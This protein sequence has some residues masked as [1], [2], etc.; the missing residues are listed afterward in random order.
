MPRFSVIIPSYLQPFKYAAT[1]RAEKFI[2][3]LD[4]LVNQT[5]TDYE[6][7]VISDGCARTIQLFEDHYAQYDFF[8]LVKL[9][10]QPLWSGEVRNAGIRIATGELITY[11]DTDD[12]LGVRHLEKLN[13]AMQNY[14]WIYYDAVMVMSDYRTRPDIA[15]LQHGF[16]GTC[17]ITHRRELNAMWLDSSYNHDWQFI[18]TLLKFENHAYT[19]AGEY[20]ICH[21]PK[22]LDV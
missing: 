14:D 16:I 13:A 6:A 4:S 2:R 22:R 19:E 15:R 21:L 8:K 5:F 20:H 10:K 17:N 9:T 3:A 7:I 1:H 18:N 12:K 11:L